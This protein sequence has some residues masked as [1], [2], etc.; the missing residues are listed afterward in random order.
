MN[1]SEG[2]EMLKNQLTRNIK[3]SMENNFTMIDRYLYSMNSTSYIEL[4]QMYKVNI[5]EYWMG[6]LY[7]KHIRRFRRNYPRPQFSETE[8]TF[9]YLKEFLNK[10]NFPSFTNEEIINEIDIFL[11][12]EVKSDLFYS[13]A[14]MYCE[15]FKEY[16]YHLNVNNTLLHLHMK[17]VEKFKEPYIFK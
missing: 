2:I 8:Q 6:N 4:K 12:D 1:Y 11:K 13:F 9:N 17:Y 15:L 5:L 7:E 3:Q 14:K 16:S 10:L